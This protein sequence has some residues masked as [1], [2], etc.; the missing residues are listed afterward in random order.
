MTSFTTNSVMTPNHSQWRVFCE[1]LTREIR[2]YGCDGTSHKILPKYK[3]NIDESLAYFNEHGGYCDC[4]ILLNVN[5]C[6]EVEAS[7]LSDEDKLL[8]L[9]HLK[10]EAEAENE[11]SDHRALMGKAALYAARNM[12]FR[13]FITEAMEAYE[14]A[15]ELVRS[16]HAEIGLNERQLDAGRQDVSTLLMDSFQQ[17]LREALVGEVE[18]EK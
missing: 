1:E 6:D 3:I 7:E 9:R 17:S 4:E 5:Q 16:R 15:I 10:E 11:R 13:D 8:L 12:R 14:C 2:R 18:A